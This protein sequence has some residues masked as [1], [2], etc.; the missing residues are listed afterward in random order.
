MYRMPHNVGLT[1]RTHEE[2]IG[3]L[4]EFTNRV[5]LYRR[6]IE[7]TQRPPCVL[8][9]RREG[10]TDTVVSITSYY[11]LDVPAQEDYNP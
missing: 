3:R 1:C 7:P 6:Y 5:A 10:E 9:W 8:G 11:I 4:W 2:Y